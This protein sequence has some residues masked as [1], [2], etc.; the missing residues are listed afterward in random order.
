M[1]KIEKLNASLSVAKEYRHLA[2]GFLADDE[3]AQINE[4]LSKMETQ[5]ETIFSEKLDNQEVE[6]FFN[7]TIAAAAEN[8][9]I[10]NVYEAYKKRGGTR[11]SLAE[12]VIDAVSFLYDQKGDIAFLLIC[13]DKAGYL[14]KIKK[15]KLIDAFFKSLKE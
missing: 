14:K 8:S 15:H 10:A 1:T 7:D 12:I 4:Q 3:L 13:L 2:H 9:Y 6:S 5:L 11:A